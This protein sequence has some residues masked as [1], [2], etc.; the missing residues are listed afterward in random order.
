MLTYSGRTPELL[1]LLHHIKHST[2]LVAITSH[3]HPSTCPLFNHRPASNCILL[4]APIPVSETVSFG[5]AAPTTSTTT[6]L[7]L[8]DALALAVAHRL[9]YSPADVFHTYH[10][11]GAIGAHVAKAGPQKMASIATTVADI[12][13]ARKQSRRSSFTSSLTALD[14]LLAAARSPSGWVRLSS[15]AIIAPRQIQRLGNDPE[16]LECDVHLLEDGMIVEKQDWISIPAASTVEEAKQWIGDMRKV[17]RGRTFLKEGTILGIV[18]AMGEVS[19]VVEIETLD[20][21]EEWWG[22]GG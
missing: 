1:Q 15:T 7:A 22:E 13:I 17:E 14:V 19:G 9:H 11:G 10:P 6:A 12:P 8:S 3:I 4:P 18:D 21:A 2:P 16:N 5:L 20:W